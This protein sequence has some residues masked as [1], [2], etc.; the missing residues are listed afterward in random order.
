MTGFQF[1]DEWRT[2]MKRDFKMALWGCLLMSAAIGP[3]FGGQDE[4][5]LSKAASG[6]GWKLVNRGEVRVGL[7]VGNNSGGDFADLK[8]IPAKA[9]GRTE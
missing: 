9:G 6:A 4:C 2:K 7:F 3:S 5:D 8:I 1:Q